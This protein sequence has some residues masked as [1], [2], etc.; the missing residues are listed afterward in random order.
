VLKGVDLSIKPGEVHALMG[1]NGSGKSTLS[2]VIMGHPKYKVTKGDVLFGGQS[3][4]F[5]KPHERALAGLFLAFQYPKEIAG[6]TLEEFLLAA[7]RAKQ[8]AH[9]PNK[10]PILVFRFQKMLK[11]LMG[12]LKIEESFAGR[13]INHGFS[14]GEKKKAEILQMAI[15]KPRMAILDETDSGLDVDA[16]KIVCDGIKTLMNDPENRM[17]LLL[18]THYPRILHYITPDFVHVL[19]NGK[20][21]K[22]GGREF[23]H[24]LDSKGYEWL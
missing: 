17:G 11:E 7:Y 3:I 13:F 16:L 24:E 5:M 2:H 19:K 22:S 21:V 8:K 9:H 15:L 20:I 23:A 12:M 6:V 4:L 14:G 1:P 10:P 18:V